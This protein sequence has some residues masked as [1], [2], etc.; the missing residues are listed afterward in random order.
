MPQVL[1]SQAKLDRG[2]E[3]EEYLRPCDSLRFFDLNRISNPHIF[4]G[5]KDAKD[6]KRSQRIA[7]PLAFLASLLSWSQGHVHTMCQARGGLCKRQQGPGEVRLD[8]PYVSNLGDEIFQN[9]PHIQQVL[10][11]QLLQTDG[12]SFVLL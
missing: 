10:I 1:L 11:M 12:L 7:L 8:L 6:P 2:Q 4:S 9:H 3:L 5:R